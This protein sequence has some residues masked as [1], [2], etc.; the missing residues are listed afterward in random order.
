VFA[1]GRLARALGSI[2]YGVELDE[3]ATRKQL[4]HVGQELV[5]NGIAIV[6]NYAGTKHPMCTLTAAEKKAADQRAK[7]DAAAKGD[8]FFHKR[9]HACG[10]AHAITDGKTATRVLTRMAKRE[11]FNLGIEP[12]KSGLMIVDLDTAE[13]KAAYTA[14]AQSAR[15]TLTVASP[16]SRDGEG[17]WV[18]RDGGHIHYEVPPDCELPIDEG[19]YTHPDGWTVTWGEHQV[20][21]PPSV[22][23]EGAYVLVGA[24]Y[25][26]PGWL[27]ELVVNETAGK[28][29]RRAEATA[30]RE[31]SG[32]SAIDDWATGHGWAPILLADGWIETGLTKS[33]GCP[34]WTAPGEHASPESATAHEPGCSTYV[35]E[36]GHG[37][38]HVWTDNPSEAIRAAIE[39]FGHKTLTM[40]QVITYTEGGGNMRATLRELGLPEVDGPAVRAAGF[41]TWDRVGELERELD[42]AALADPPP[43]RDAPGPPNADADSDDETE[44]G[45]DGDEDRAAAIAEYEERQIQIEATRLR[46]QR[47]AQRRIEAEGAPALRVLRGENFLNAPRPTPLV[48]Q[49]LYRDSLARIYGAPGSGKSFV[50]LDIA[51][52]IALGKWFDGVRMD[53]APVVYVMAEGQ[54]VNA[55]RTEAWLSKHGAQLTENFIVVPDA[56]MLTEF[57]AR[58]LVSLVEREQPVLVVLDT[59]NAMMIGEENSATDFAALR[60]TL[61]LIR[62]AAGCCVVLVDHTGYEGTRARGSSAGTAAMDTEIRVDKDD[63][64][65]PSIVAAEV[66][67]DKASEAGATWTWNLVPEH[68]AA[69]LIKPPDGVGVGVVDPDK[70]EWRDAARDYSMPQWIEDKVA[71]KVY[72]VELA[73]YMMFETSM[74]QDPSQHGKSLAQAVAAIKP[75]TVN[76]TAAAAWRSGLGRAWSQLKAKGCMSYWDPNG[77]TDLQ[78]RSGPHLWTGPN[79]S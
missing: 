4:I 66:T 51:L 46:R 31:R 68:P 37:P 52:S 79:G 29:K 22:R 41:S 78:E 15:P 72:L 1:G 3:D 70:L 65:K 23:A 19:I 38:L 11:R 44:T 55:D 10:L 61:D 43:P 57:A 75:A 35:C 42:D 60:R 13:Q 36:R 54:A 76:K 2:Q 21:V 25:P 77:G 8:P 63:S 71:G 12:R 73:R 50:A 20:L 32:P 39:A 59:K 53:A 24:T 33:C 47:E 9:V 17:T 16:G 40:A 28:R 45:D 64:S 49:M 62:K 74:T 18:H 34:Q 27:R 58:D 48:N 14:C 7:D 6:L 30:L 5:A 56:V 26:L 67:R 69:V